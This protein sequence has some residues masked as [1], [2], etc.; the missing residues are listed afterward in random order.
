M[1]QAGGRHGGPVR[2]RGR[3]AIRPTGGESSIG[4][5][6]DEFQAAA[7]TIC[8]LA[9]ASAAPVIDF[10]HHYA[11]AI[12]QSHPVAAVLQV[13]GNLIGDQVDSGDQLVRGIARNE[14]CVILRDYHIAIR[15][16]GHVVGNGDLQSS[17]NF[18]SAQILG[19]LAAIVNLDELMI[20]ITRNRVE[21]DFVDH[22]VANQ[23][24]S[25]CPTRR[26]G[27]QFAEAAGCAI[28]CSA[29]RNIGSLVLEENGI[30]YPRLVGT[31]EENLIPSRAQIGELPGERRIGRDQESIKAARRNG[32]SCW[33]RE[34]CQVAFATAEI[35]AREVNGGVAIIVKL[36]VLGLPVG[37]IG[38][39]LVDPNGAKVIEAVDFAVTWRSAD[40]CAGG[41]SARVS[42][43][44]R[45]P[46]QH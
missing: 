14:I 7:S 43:A 40:R 8:P 37:R 20:V 27:D 31:S 11:V 3:V 6:I 36:D 38:E 9:P 22:K 13:S 21:H 35:G 19:C 10:C 39:E 1:H 4:A 45:R 25:V 46:R 15:G 2:L 17:A 23:R 18:P 16:D 5:G 33:N 12:L 26:A 42:F 28:S 41:P 34:I 30:H 44:I 29:H 24:G 32:G